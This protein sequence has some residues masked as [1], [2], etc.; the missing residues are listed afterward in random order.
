[1]ALEALGMVETRGLTAA[2]E[3][4][5]AMV[6]A[7]EVSWKVLSSS[8][9]IK[10]DPLT[11]FKVRKM[12]IPACIAGWETSKP[13]TTKT[14]SAGRPGFWDA[15]SRSTDT[16]SSTERRRHELETG[17]GGK[18]PKALRHAAS[19]PQHPH[20]D[21]AA[22]AGGGHRISHGGRRLPDLAGHWR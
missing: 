19:H 2:I 8:K 10:A 7:A 17:S 3:A 9:E 22:G 21:R 15:G 11:C 16:G 1:M 4:A 12:K 14:A 13:A 6:K 20:G 18:T 5:D